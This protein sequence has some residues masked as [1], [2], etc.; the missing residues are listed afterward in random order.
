MAASFITGVVLRPHEVEWTV[1]Y[2]SRKGV[3]VVEHQRLPLPSA[4]TGDPYGTA[5][6]KVVLKQLAARVRGEVHVSVASDKAL[7]RVVDLPSSDPAEW[8]NMAELQVD[9]FSPFPVEQMAT[10]V[11]PL[12]RTDKSTRVLI[13]T[14]Q[15]EIIGK[16]G[17]VLAGAGVRAHRVDVDVMGWWALLKAERAAPD[18]GRAVLLLLDRAGAELVITQDGLPMLIR[19]LGRSTTSDQAFYSEVAEEVGY[20]LT[21]V[22][23]EL[24]AGAPPPLSIW[25]RAGAP[26][27]ELAKELQAAGTAMPVLH[28]LDRL[29][30]LSEG[31]ARRGR[32]EDPRRLNLAPAE[33]LLD[34]SSRK[35]RRRFLAATA[36]FLA[37][38]VAALGGAWLGLDLQRQR[39][40]A[41]QQKV[42]QLEEPSVRV[43]ALKDKVQTFEQYSDRTYSALECLRE[44]S[45]L[46][47]AG[48]DL[49]SFFYKKGEG[50]NLKGETGNTDLIYNFADA[51]TNSTLLRAGPP[52]DLKPKSSQGRQAWEFS[53]ALQVLGGAVEGGETP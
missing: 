28:A 1:L 12:S 53:L 16:L 32:Q 17:A 50:V 20:T 21:S 27:D 10:A 43:R 45:A 25:H 36:A 18:Q 4:E 49:T 51:F 34:E 2:T 42:Q 15:R 26:I 8:M 31:I 22:E 9:K 6:A 11:E 46:L 52:K 37:L 38:W 3:E 14:I 33:W 35:V 24:G 13:A 40:T 23:T 7:L 41:L 48:I 5:E 44:V 47:P 39:I 30:P 29:P 19:S